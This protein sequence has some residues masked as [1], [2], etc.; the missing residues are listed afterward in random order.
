M[1]KLYPNRMLHSEPELHEVEAPQTLLEYF[2]AK[3]LSRDADVCSL[4][5]TVWHDGVQV[6][7]TAWKD[8][9]V[10]P[11]D[12]ISM[13][14]EPKGTDP[15]SITFALVFGA[16]A[17][18]SALMPKLPGLP[19][20]NSKKGKDLDDASAKGNKV[21]VNDLVPECAGFNRRFP[22]YAT[23]G[24]RRYYESPRAQW[25][26]MLLCVGMGSFQIQASTIKVG[27]TPMLSL[28]SDASF[29]IY[30]PG[31]DLS[32]DPAHLYWYQAPEVGQASSGAAGLE[33]TVSSNLTFAATASV[34]QYNSQTIS[35]PTGAGSFPADWVPGLLIAIADPYDY[36]IADGT[37][38]GGRDV[39]SG[40]NVANLGFVAGDLIEIQGANSGLYEVFSATATQLQLN[41]AGGASGTGL[42]VGTQ[43]M[44]IGFRGLRY[45]IVSYSAQSLLV[46]RLKTNGTTDSGWPG[47][48]S[49]SSNAGRVQL[50]A[51]NLQGGYR[52]PFVASPN[53]AL[54]TIVEYDIQLPAGLIKFN[55]NGSPELISVT[56]VF[57][58]RDA[59]LQGSWNVDSHT[60]TGA[61]LDAQGYTYRVV[62]PYPMRVECRLRRT[63]T[64]VTDST[65]KADTMLWYGLRACIP[66]ASPVQYPDKT[67]ISVRIRGGERIS[68]QTDDLVS[69]ECTRILPV[70]NGYGAWGPAVPTRQISAWIGYIARSVGYSDSDLDMAELQRLEN[71][72]T[73]R[74]DYYDKIITSA[75]TVKEYM[76][77][78][79]QA[80]FSELTLD[81]GVITPVRDEPRQVIQHIYDPM[82]MTKPL[83][84]DASY[85][86]PDDFDGVDVEYFDRTTRANETVECRWY[87]NGVREAGTRIDKMKLEGVNDRNRAY[88][89][90]MRR[91]GAQIFRDRTYTFNTELDALNSGY[92]DYAGLGDQVIGYGESAYMTSFA[93]VGDHYFVGT[94]ETFDWSA[95]GVFKMS[96]RR[97]D[98]S[99]AGPY[100][101]TRVSD[102]VV[103]IS[104]LEFDTDPRTFT[105][106]L[107]GVMEPPFL[108]FGPEDRWVYPALI[109]E[110]SPS[111]SDGCKVTAV[112][113]DARVYQYDSANADN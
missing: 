18:L 93:T 59:D 1:I 33:L 112:N 80:G 101:A 9:I 95:G 109:T 106:D 103:S 97:K 27:E 74:G 98:G 30:P 44:S 39:I 107:S 66:A 40:G 63:P 23:G 87:F 104:K 72:W 3:G 20:S 10:K 8:Y 105:P 88:R 14:R 54:A 50:D 17:I 52:G 22:D 34:F 92:L 111:G 67:M 60:L 90:G 84:R 102:R 38:T 94:S 6:L 76:I 82:N 108:R 83:K 100:N 51:S 2:W 7:P 25:L 24:F 49:N 43:T 85:V 71:I 110:V 11:D 46:E 5:M 45:R 68:S 48:V 26:E 31:A 36:S 91:R 16:K 29:I 57:E 15:F 70:L 55:S 86:T 56:S 35:I 75:S 69:L 113:Y 73:A 12:D 99:I 79:L 47:W 32:N 28:G 61:T 37:G 21:K 41:Y 62:L 77:E 65:K 4:P 96:I 19:S 89:I 64:Q 81:R 58:W 78:A 53:G 42:A 13:F